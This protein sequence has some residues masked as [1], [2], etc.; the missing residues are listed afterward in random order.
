MLNIPNPYLVDLHWLLLTI[1]L[2]DYDLDLLDLESPDPMSSFE[3]QPQTFF[4]DLPY[5]IF[6]FILNL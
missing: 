3:T 6:T 5:L 2:Y 1:A 4:W